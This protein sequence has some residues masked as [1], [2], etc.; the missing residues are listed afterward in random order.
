MAAPPDIKDLAREWLRLDRDKSTTDEIYKLLVQGN[1]NEL[2]SRLRNRIAF[3]TAGLR[4]P[5]QAGFACMNSL[6]VIQASQGLAAYLL[7]TEAQAKKRGVVIGYDARHNSE[8]FAKL[9]AAAFV[10][11]GIKVWW[12]DMP[13]H[14]PMVPFGVRELD[15]VA[16]IMI[17]ASHNPARDNGYKVYWSNGC[18]IIPPH[19][20]GIANAILDHLEPVSWDT[21]V[22]DS[23]DMLVEGALGLVQDQYHRAVKIA[24]RPEGYSETMDPKLRFVYT[25]MHGV[26]LP[27]M[28][29][30][31]RD[32]GIFSQM[33]V[34]EA[35]AQPDPDFP[36]VKF[37]NPE[38]KGALDLAIATADSNSIPLILA[39]DPDAD[40]LAAAEKVSNAWH[41]FTGNE[42]G[43]LIGS[44]LFE[45]YPADKPRDKM[46]M[47]A[48][49][50]SS[51]MLHALAQKE[52]FHF[53]ETLTGFK[54]LGNVSRDLG[55]EGYDVIYAYEEALGYMIPQ[56]VHDK[57]SIS[58]AAVF[59][60]AVSHWSSQNLTPYS[61]L[62]KLYEH[63]GFFAD[64]NTYLTSPSPTTTSTV[65]AA[66]RA[67]GDP[68][69]TTIGTRKIVRWRDLTVG[70]DS[71]SEDHVPDLPV[72]PTAQMITCELDDGARFT[73]RGSGTEP[74]IKMYI[75]CVGSSA[76]GA[77]KGALEIQNAL[78]E[79]WFK[80]DVYGLKLA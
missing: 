62:Q 35:Q 72:D 10:A 63:I 76:D 51:R 42:L 28:Q 75:E 73:V 22:V 18:Q 23:G 34:V 50:V 26:G 14:T 38:E 33:V 4:G 6:T 24:A 59:L 8:K 64:A 57:D 9:T 31:A 3:G 11:K 25:P 5:M 71:K 70:W 58:A 37:P 1:T 7:Q 30:C 13:T 46:A 12:Y 32:L 40:R 39:S 54:W 74:K 67:A 44:Y 48:S 19:D 56:T 65:F 53:V 80:P 2:E 47:L 36:T 20:T 45:R 68:Y 17:T 21:S 55:R 52:G 29:Q 79:E 66:I 77:R 43:I 61:K 27:A 15:A 78:L 69:P 60:T 49:T 16:G 41:I